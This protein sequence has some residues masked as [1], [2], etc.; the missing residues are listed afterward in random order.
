MNVLPPSR[1]Y[2]PILIYT[3]SKLLRFQAVYSQNR[4]KRADS[5]RKPR[6]QCEIAWNYKRG[7][8]LIDYNGDDF[9]IK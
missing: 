3:R 1:F 7:T 2:P 4:L 8:L 5:T 9:E 6:I